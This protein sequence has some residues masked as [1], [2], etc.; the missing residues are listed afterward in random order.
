MTPEQTQIQKLVAD[1]YE[2]YRVEIAPYYPQ[3]LVYVLPKATKYGSIL[4]PEKDQNKPVHEGLVVRTYKPFWKRELRTN[5]K[6]EEEPYKE[7]IRCRMEVGQHV[8]FHH[9]YGAPIPRMDPECRGDQWRLVTESALLA[10]LDYKR[11]KPAE[12]LFDLVAGKDGEAIDTKYTDEVKSEVE[13]FL[14][15]W[16]L[17]EKDLTARTVSGA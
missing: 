10:V 12:V 5:E 13:K 14:T 8:L 9:A 11:Q 6:G 15:R 7:E 4:L 17:V 2:S 3:V 1:M 16:N